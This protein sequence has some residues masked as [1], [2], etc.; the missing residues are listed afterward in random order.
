MKLNVKKVRA[1]MERLKI[2]ESD[3]ARG[4]KVTRQNVWYMLH[5][6][7]KTFRVIDRLA[8][9]FSLDAKDLIK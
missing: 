1:E 7:S 6:G 2:T 4:L 5:G 3:L 9:Y 8:K